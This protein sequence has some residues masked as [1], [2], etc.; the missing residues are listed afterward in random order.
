[1][2]A[3]S[4]IKSV[5]E[6]FPLVPRSVAGRAVLGKFF[7]AIS[8]PNRLALLE[9]LVGE[10]HTGNECVAV[11]GLA[12]SRVSSHLQCLVNCGFITVRREG[13]FAYYRVDD[14]RV[15]DLVRLG[16]G[17]A[18]DHAEAVAACTRLDAI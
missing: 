7:R 18:A 9:F 3:M 4:T 15:V 12:Q 8:D 11:L 5:Q 17:I 1:M 16:V 14:P 2:R 13:H 6:S 10:E